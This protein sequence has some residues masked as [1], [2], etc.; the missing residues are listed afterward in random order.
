MTQKDNMGSSSSSQKRSDRVPLPSL[1]KIGSEGGGGTQQSTN[2][3]VCPLVFRVPLNDSKLLSEGRQ[4]SIVA[5]GT[6]Q[7]FGYNVGVLSKGQAKIIERCKDLGVIY[8]G[9][10][11]KIKTKGKIVYYGEFRQK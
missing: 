3:A 7:M 6:I 4:L 10:V 2:E 5:G 8:I 9:S 1:K 11:V